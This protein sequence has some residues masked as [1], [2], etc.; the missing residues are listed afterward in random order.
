MITT[1]GILAAFGTAACKSITDL[2]TKASTRRL[3]DIRNFTIQWTIPAIIL[4]LACIAMN[5][6]FL[7]HPIATLRTEVKDGFWTLLLVSG[8]LNVVAGYSYV[9]AFRLSDASLV[10]PVMLL[11]PILLLVTSRLMLGQ[12]IPFAGIAGVLCAVGGSYQLARSVDGVSARAAYAAFFRDKGVRAMMLTACIWSVTNNFDKLGVQASSPLIWGAGMS[13]ILA[14]SGLMMFFF[15]GGEALTGRNLVYGVLPG[16]SNSGM[17][18]LQL[19]AITVIP[20]PYVIAIKRFST[21]FTVIGGG[22]FFGEKIRERLMGTVITLVGVL[23]IA[24]EIFMQ[25]G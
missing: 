13:I 10:A 22:V 21:V 16:A 4:T 6:S 24:G 18:L 14:A 25:R 23:V 12:E 17:M 2:G 15:T 3:D 19:Y 11:T 5:P 20:V 9:R 8:V 1:L 7:S